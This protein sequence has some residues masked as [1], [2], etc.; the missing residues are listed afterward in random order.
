MKDAST[1]LA[2]LTILTLEGDAP[3]IVA[4]DSANNRLI[5]FRKDGEKE[6]VAAYVDQL[7]EKLV[8]AEELAASKQRL[9]AR[10]PNVASRHAAPYPRRP[11]RDHSGPLPAPAPGRSVPPISWK[12]AGGRNRK[13]PATVVAPPTRFTRGGI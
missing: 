8:G 3:A 2:G 13:A 7:L 12:G 10:N 4:S 11:A 6:T 5:I 9:A 1:S